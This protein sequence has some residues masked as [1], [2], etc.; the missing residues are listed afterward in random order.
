[1]LFFSR[2]Q[3]EL[4]QKLRRLTKE[5]AESRCEVEDVQKFLNEMKDRSK[6]PDVGNQAFTKAAKANKGFE[7]VLIVS[8]S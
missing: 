4:E 8:T 1:M 5:R 6:S 7:N 2:E 3:K